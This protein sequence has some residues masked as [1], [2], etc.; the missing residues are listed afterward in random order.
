[1]S[2]RRRDSH[3]LQGKRNM[4]PE[5]EKMTSNSVKSSDACDESV[6]LGSV[7]MCK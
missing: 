2:A 5:M 3:T 6:T 4:P 1:M 7:Y